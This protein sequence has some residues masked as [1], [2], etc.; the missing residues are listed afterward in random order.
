VDACR[1][2][3]RLDLPPVRAHNVRLALARGLALAGRLTEAVDVFR[4]AT[5]VEPED[6]ASHLRLGEALLHFAGDAQSAVEEFQL[7]LRLDP[8]AA[9]TYGALGSALHVLGQYPEAAAAFAEAVRLSPAY[10]ASRPAAALQAEASERG[11]S[12][13]EPSGH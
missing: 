9:E 13:L 10:L 7:A 11:R 8:R 12:W 3:L 5:R 2:A 4:E 1:G 6:A